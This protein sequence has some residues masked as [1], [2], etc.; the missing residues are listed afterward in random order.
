MI[1]NAFRSENRLVLLF[2]FIMMGISVFLRSTTLMMP[3]VNDLYSFRQAQTAITIQDY[4]N[5]GFSVFNY[6]TPV[7]GPPW[8]APM[9]FPIYQIT[10]F[11]F[12]QLFGMQNIDLACRIISIIYFYLS[13]AALLYLTR[14]IFGK[15][16]IYITVFLFY[17]F[18]PFNVI[19]SRAA[20]PDFAS[21]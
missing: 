17:I 11:F 6:T 4:F 3:L 13:A 15:K 19:Y 5:H 2:I 7:F 1:K 14:Y 12:M 21:G 20:L 18:A 9:E 8:L 10:V 16:E